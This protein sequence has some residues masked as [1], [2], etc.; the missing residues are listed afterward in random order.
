V[1][2]SLLCN[3]LFCILCVSM[4]KY[5]QY[6]SEKDPSLRY[7]NIKNILLLTKKSYIKEVVFRTKKYVRCFFTKPKKNTSTYK[8]LGIPHLQWGSEYWTFEYQNHSNNRTFY[9]TIW[10]VER[11]S[12]IQMVRKDL[13]H[14]NTR[15]FNNRACFYHLNTRHVWYSDPPLYFASY[16]W[17]T[18]YGSTNYYLK[19][20]L[21]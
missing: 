11:I 1:L 21:Q 13:D 12:S 16:L 18:F 4:Y 10:I 17:N 6:V 2:P 8:F 9:S 7:D 15:P 14:L 20:K 3:S 5:R 19:C